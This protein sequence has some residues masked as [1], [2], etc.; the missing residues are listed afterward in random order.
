MGT[1]ERD[2]ASRESKRHWGVGKVDERGEKEIFKIAKRAPYI[3]KVSNS[4]SNIRFDLPLFSFY[5]PPPS[6]LDVD[7]QPPSLAS[8]ADAADTPEY[9][10]I[11]F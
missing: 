9:A 10:P 11:F 4:D 1:A 8:P 5:S 7:P 6:L 2:L 3:Y